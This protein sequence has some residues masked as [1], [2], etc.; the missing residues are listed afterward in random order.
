MGRGLLL[1]LHWDNLLLY[2]HLLLLRYQLGPMRW[3][4][5]SS[6][7][8]SAD[9]PTASPNPVPQL[10]LLQMLQLPVLRHELALCLPPEGRDERDVCPLL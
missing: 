10:L 3:R 5:C 7:S 1:P 6:A 9:G 4:T 8:A 2:R